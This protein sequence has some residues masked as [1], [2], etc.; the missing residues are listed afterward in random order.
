MDSSLGLFQFLSP[1]DL[2]L[3]AISGLLY[4]GQRARHRR[5]PAYLRPRSRK[6]K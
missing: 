4:W 2:V 1:C 5:T 3:L 6:L